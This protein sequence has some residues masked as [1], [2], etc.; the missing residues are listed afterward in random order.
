MSSIISIMMHRFE[1]MVRYS[2]GHVLDVGCAD[3]AQWRYPL[4][5]GTITNPPNITNVT[6]ADCDQW[7]NE[8]GLEFIRCFAENVPKSNQ[9]YDTVIYGDILEHVNDPNIVLQ[10]GKRLTRDRIIISVPNEYKWLKDSPY[11]LSFETR[12]KHLA[13]GKDLHELGKD[14]TIRHPSGA[15][16]DALDDVEFE[17]IHHKRFY[18][19]E[20]F[21]KLIEDNFDS[22]EWSWHIYNI[23]YS[24]LNFV[25][26]VAVIWRK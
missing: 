5:Q 18:N 2:K 23:H 7:N 22:K 15:C 14:S 12:E 17:H 1:F 19:E 6:L 3:C 10:E 16:T 25:N 24:S 9:S 21:T 20:T 26:L 13:D 11:V 4:P 8:M